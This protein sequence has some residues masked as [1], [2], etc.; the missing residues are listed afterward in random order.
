MNLIEFFS[1]SG[2]WS[3][4]LA[5]RIDSYPLLPQLKW[6]QVM[7]YCVNLFALFSCFQP[8]VSYA[9]YAVAGLM[10]ILNHY[11][12]PQ[13]RKPLPWLCFAK[14]FLRSR[15]YNQFEVKGN[16]SVLNQIK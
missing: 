1:L 8:Y 9:L 2:P 4:W 14:P 10:G 15:E 11:L 5:T 12:W 16:K 13:V 7:S 6:A 3:V